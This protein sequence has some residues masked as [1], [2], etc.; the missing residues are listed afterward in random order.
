MLLV[1]SELT[2]MGGVKFVLGL[3]FEI[4][5]KAALLLL[6]LSPIDYAFQYYQHMESLKMTP[7]QVDDERKQR[8]GN[9]E[10]KK[11]QQEKM[12]EQAQRRMMEQ[13][14]EAD[15]VI[16]NP[17][18]YAVALRYNEKET[19][20]PVLI[21]KGEGMVAQR[22]KSVAAEHGVPIY[23]V[24]LLAR[25]LIQLELEQEIPPDLYNAVAEVLA[26]VHQNRT[27]VSR[28]EAARLEQEVKELD[29]ATAG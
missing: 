8:E 11:K 24:P 2:L 9:P 13:V 22:I 28:R 29:L 15:V 17:T 19:Q 21:A 4:I 3:A 16:T 10:I 12:Q 7:Q 18:H 5:F 1:L 23:E 27:D 25:T 6:I 14:P 26:W 20:A